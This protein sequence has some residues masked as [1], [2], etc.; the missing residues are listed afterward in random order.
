M[1]LLFLGGAACGEQEKEQPSTSID[2]CEPDQALIDE[3]RECRRDDHCPCGSHCSLGQCTAACT[4]TDDCADGQTCDSFGRCRG[5]A[6]GVIAVRNA[7]SEGRPRILQSGVI[8]GTRAEP[9]LLTITADDGPLHSARITADPGAEIALAVAD[10]DPASLDYATELLVDTEVAE[11]ETVNIYVRPLIDAASG[12]EPEPLSIQVINASNVEAEVVVGSPSTWRPPATPATTLP[13]VYEGYA[14][15][16]LTGVG[17]AFGFDAL[18]PQRD[19]S[20]LI[21]AEVYEPEGDRAVIVIR[22]PLRLVHPDGEWVG[23][24]ILDDN[25]R[26]ELPA[27]EQLAETSIAGS[28]AQ[29][30]AEPADGALTTDPQAGDW[31]GSLG[32]SLDLLFSGA[33]NSLYAPRQ[34]WEFG[35][36]RQGDLSDGASAP[37]LQQP[38]SLSFDPDVAA[39]TALA[40][41]AA[42]LAAAVPASSPINYNPDIQ[43]GWRRDRL[44]AAGALAPICQDI[45]NAPGNDGTRRRIFADFLRAPA[46]NGLEGFD[47]SESLSFGS[48][49]TAIAIRW[50]GEASWSDFTSH[51]GAAQKLAAPMTAPVVEA[52][53]HTSNLEVW[54]FRLALG[55]DSLDD[56]AYELSDETRLEHA[57]PCAWDL[58]A[59]P[60]P[61]VPFTNIDN[62]SVSLDTTSLRVNVCDRMK[63]T[64]EC[65]VVA[66]SGNVADAD[67]SVAASIT[68]ETIGPSFISPPHAQI[69]L[70]DTRVDSVCVFPRQPSLCAERAVCDAPSRSD[71][72]A[73]TQ[74]DSSVGARTGELG[75]QDTAQGMWWDVDTTTATADEAMVNCLADLDALNDAPASPS[76]STPK[77]RLDSIGWYDSSSCV[78]ALRFL[79]TLMVAGD[80]ARQFSMLG[81]DRDFDRSD[82]IFLRLLQRYLQIVEFSVGE[83]ASGAALAD[84]F[85]EDT[86][87]A[88]LEA[89]LAQSVR[90][91]DLVLHPRVG[92][93]LVGVTDSALADPDYRTRI[94]DTPPTL[95]AHHTQD[96]GVVVAMMSLLATQMELIAEIADRRARGG[97]D[98]VPD[99]IVDALRRI[100]LIEAHVAMFYSRAR[101]ADNAT[102]PRWLPTYD[103]ARGRYESARARAMVSLSAAVR[104]TNPLGIEDDDLPLYFS[105]VATDAGSRY[106]AISDYIL[107][108]GPLS[109][110]IAQTAVQRA[111]DAFDAARDAYLAEAQRQ[112]N[113]MNAD[114]DLQ[115]QIT[116][117]QESLGETIQDLC[118]ESLFPGKSAQE[119]AST[120]EANPTT[121]TVDETTGTRQRIRGAVDFSSCWYRDLPECKE[122]DGL[123]DALADAEALDALNREEY[124]RTMEAN[125]RNRLCVAALA[126]A[127]AQLPRCD[128]SISF[129]T[130]LGPVSGGCLWDTGFNIEYIGLDCSAPANNPATR[131]TA[132]SEALRKIERK[133]LADHRASLPTLTRTFLPERMSGFSCGN[134]PTATK[135]T[136]YVPFGAGEN[137]CAGDGPGGL[138]PQVVYEAT[139][140]EGNALPEDQRLRLECATSDGVMISE[141]IRASEL[142]M[143]RDVDASRVLAARQACDEVYPRQFVSTTTPRRE[144]E[145]TKSFCY[146][147]S[148]GAQASTLRSLVGSVEVARSELADMQD[149]YRIAMESCFLLQRGNER[150]DGARNAFNEELSKMRTA[151]TAMDQAANVASEVKD[152]LATASG[153]TADIT[154]PVGTATSQG[155]AAGSCAAGLVSAGLQNVSL[156][157]ERAMGD[158]QDSHDDMMAELEAATEE[159]RCFKEA[160]LSKVAERTLELNILV[161]M[162]DVESGYAEFANQVEQAQ[163]AAERG[164]DSIAT[165]RA[166]GASTVSRDPWLNA[167]IERYDRSM[168][169]ARRAAYLAVRAVEYEF[170]MTSALRG[171]VLIAKTVDELEVVLQDLRAVTATQSPNGNQPASLTEVFSLRDHL[172]QVGARDDVPAGESSL[173]AAERFRLRLLDPRYEVYEDGEFIGRDIPFVIAPLAKLDRGT[174]AGVPIVSDNS[175][176]ERLWSLN[177]SIQ[178]EPEQTFSGFAPQ[179]NVEIRKRNTFFANWCADA[180]QPFQVASTRPSKNLFRE[181]GIAEGFEGA[182]G[183]QTDRF[184]KA[185]IQALLDIPTGEFLTDAYVDGSSDELAGRLLFGDY[186]LFIPA[187]S[188]ASFDE[189]TGEAVS[190][191]LILSEV[192]D[193]AIRLDYI[194][195]AR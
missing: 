88:D 15:L 59:N 126:P 172:L 51:S 35:L 118:G 136:A 109:N 30:I 77:E 168:R 174:T 188:L 14:R 127:E 63:Q 108:D 47:G 176:G 183:S 130:P 34:V 155:L 92:S 32:F 111:R 61:T 71:A 70:P 119:V 143:D 90:G 38:A 46:L 87:V 60:S 39:D 115:S 192:D 103:L 178:G 53:S 190:D 157:L 55:G 149:E 45:V 100:S 167:D 89:S 177:V 134:L 93:A 98:E 72:L 170:Q 9:R 120:Y 54:N 69:D 11:G 5:G 180:E 169:L 159:A 91:W 132:S 19:V 171:A 129:S 22:D 193:I 147:G 123:E 33:S 113:V 97:A 191:G 21:T 65:S 110:A 189:D 128:D 73:P 8:A 23:E 175:C 106:T 52:M 163:L 133:L 66:L 185:R 58:S 94:L 10:T 86:A 141:Y 76:G 74:L 56:Y 165:A 160:E 29:I 150:L 152:C 187:S 146:R 151:K 1:T 135:S 138:W 57:V 84:A 166:S 153:A 18:K 137:P 162:Q 40:H 95:E 156:E 36:S 82:T 42:F 80:S 96:E 122:D 28:V 83:V 144:F 107:G 50:D 3:A 181:P 142:A 49:F 68:I 117:A 64:Y 17:G 6:A 12:E 78:N 184:S 27:F 161:A 41:E 104:G 114:S 31:T 7:A 25:P 125:A 20:T 158:L 182:G 164:R 102:N 179:V 140:A 16:N 145:V 85:T 24:V 48:G 79:S 131:P 99:S 194:S 173:S 139:D 121:F 81:L 148:L 67:R 154:N 75:C 26:V 105:Q 13:G 101:N 116:Q 112:V 186:S 62:E 43:S 2:R 37:A 4:S 195:V 124:A 44:E